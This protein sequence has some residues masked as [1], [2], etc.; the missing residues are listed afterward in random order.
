MT[1]EMKKFNSWRDI[2]KWLNENGYEP[3]ARRM[4]LNNDCWNSSGEFGRSQITI[5]DAMRFCESE[6]ERHEAA[7]S[8]QE[9][10]YLI[11]LGLVK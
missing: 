3:L 9:N 5:C 7:R 8:L 11:E 10:D 6:D 4:Q 1:K 2:Q